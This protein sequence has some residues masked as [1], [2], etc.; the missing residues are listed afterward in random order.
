MINPAPFIDH[1]LLKPDAT[2][3]M[4]AVLCEEAVEYGFASVCLPPAFVPFAVKRLY[5]SEVKVCT[6]VGF[7]CGYN[8]LHQKVTETSELV[9]LG[10]EEID[11]VIPVGRLIERNLLLVEEEI[12][13]IVL[14]SEQVPVK[15]II[16]CCYLDDDL[17]RRATE[18]VVK[19][20]AAYVKTS[21][22]FGPSGATVADV[23]L[24][25]ATAAGRIGVKA[26]GGIR[27]LSCFWEMIAAGATRVG[28]SS[29]VKIVSAW[30]KL[31]NCKD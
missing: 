30:H 20:G 5:G 8:T 15:V 11:M 7:P 25:A 31:Q 9:A 13:Q 2:E 10:A 18:V 4:F 29:G 27:D 23:R 24:L 6:V 1:T 14:A 3:A 22:G 26:A 12:S 19:A 28:T 21:T 16:E 17:K